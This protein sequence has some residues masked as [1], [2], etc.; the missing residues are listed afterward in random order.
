MK[1]FNIL[2]AADAAKMKVTMA[3]TPEKLAAMLV[4]IN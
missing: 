3:E 1:A 2:T 4:T